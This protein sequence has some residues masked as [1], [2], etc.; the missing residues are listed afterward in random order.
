MV[1]QVRLGELVAW[2]A[3]LCTAGAKPAG[4]SVLTARLPIWGAMKCHA[5][6]LWDQGT[7]AVAELRARFQQHRPSPVK[8]EERSR[9][10]V[11]SAGV[12][13]LVPVGGPVT[14]GGDTEE[15]RGH[16]PPPSEPTCQSVLQQMDPWVQETFGGHIPARRGRG[17]VERKEPTHPGGPGGHSAVQRRMLP[18]SPHRARSHPVTA[19]G[20]TWVPHTRSAQRRVQRGSWG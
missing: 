14:P 11:G 18:R 20:T 19:V 12:S 2:P 8:L 10:G 6:G 13:S 15:G 7:G 16:S 5:Q 4:A 9:L 1:L 3:L 17:H